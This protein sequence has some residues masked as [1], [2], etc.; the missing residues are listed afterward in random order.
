MST[1]D[2]TDPRADDV[3]NISFS[4]TEL[5]DIVNSA[6]ITEENIA[7]DDL[8]EYGVWVKV[9][10]EDVA[11]S[12][13]DLPS[14]E[15]DAP[16]TDLDEAEE[17]FLT[18]EEESLL[19]ELGDVDGE[20]KRDA[21]DAGALADADAMI[22]TND[23]L[24]LDIPDV[25][26][27]V[28]G[29][30][31]EEEPELDTD[32]ELAEV[33]SAAAGDEPSIDI[34][35]DDGGDAIEV[36]LTDDISTETGELGDLA[37][38]GTDESVP[39]A[40]DN[41][42][43][44]P[45]DPAAGDT[46]SLLAKMERELLAI[47]E[48]ITD[49]KRELSELRKGGM[50]SAEP[51]SEPTG[52][53]DGDDDETIALT[54]D[55]LDNI[56]SSAD[57]TEEI[58]EAEDAPAALDLGG[59]A[60]ASAGVGTDVDL[61][62]DDALGTDVDLGTGVDLDID[63]GVD[64]ETADTEAELA[65]ESAAPEIDLEI[66]DIGGDEDSADSL[67]DGEDLLGGD[68]LG[69]TDTGTGDEGFDL[70]VELDAPA[71][72]PPPAVEEL[73]LDDEPMAAEAEELVLDEAPVA[74]PEELMLEDEPAAA[75]REGLVLEEEPPAEPEEL[76]LDEEPTPVEAEELILEEEPAAAEPAEAV[77]GTIELEEEI[78]GGEDALELVEEL[79]ASEPEIELAPAADAAEVADV[80]LN[81]D[82]D[83]Q[84]LELVDEQPLDLEA[85]GDGDDG[86]VLE[87]EE[88]ADEPAA[89]I[90]DEL[91]DEHRGDAGTITLEG[92]DAAVPDDLKQDIK[93]VLAYLDQLLDALPE[94]KI[95]EFAQSEHF[96]VYKKLFEELGLED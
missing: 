72:D 40:I 63:L 26:D 46:A 41:A 79:E 86:E 76:I 42:P 3:E 70:E 11:E 92:A 52:F 85:A 94:D 88:V 38:L 7:D 32:F 93:S 69:D 18:E 82:D 36:P 19:G 34:A 84:S 8:E 96:G 74:E 44:A 77:P 6:E 28:E 37:D 47:M 20:A 2:H 49:V 30:E 9:G 35:A 60:D 33:E 68:A 75:E 90:S 64:T 21:S 89:D 83:D 54:G 25:E 59:E 66:G 95:E 17:D 91:P 23:D 80:D 10:P 58:A 13:D 57:I 22:G 73:V 55:E 81:I 65:T 14:A 45:A 78:A 27:P 43:A 24:D 29:E 56:L 15:N 61:G 48:E 50:S 62:T 53:F 39:L 31:R 16:L 67:I 1:D 71:A 5:D 51:K 87:I 4:A 12:A